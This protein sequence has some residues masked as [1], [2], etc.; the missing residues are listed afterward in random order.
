MARM[1]ALLD[2]ADGHRVLEIG[3]GTGYHAAL[4]SH[5]L[6]DTGVTSVDI[7][8]ALVGTARD[9]LAGLGYRPQLTAG[10]GAAGVA[11][12]APYNRIIA[13]CG[14]PEIP[15]AW[16]TQLTAGGLIVADV[17]SEVASSLVVAR[18]STPHSVTGRFLGHSG[19]FMWMRARVDN[20]LRTG[21]ASGA[22]YD[23]T[24]PATD[25]TNIPLAAFD[26]EDFRFVLQLAVPRLRPVGHTIRDGRDGIFLV[27]DDTP[28]WVE[29][30]PDTGRGSTVRYGGPRPLWPGIAAAWQSWNVKPG[31]G[32]R[33]P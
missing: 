16:I 9:R 22:V 27:T 15:P 33:A 20:P 6:G 3:T 19:H 11:G 1:L 21:G 12:Q 14:V 23:F 17:R 32:R 26:D 29:I 10:D 5:R 7:D 18:K 31:G 2:V 28:A 4:L 25:T 30:S 24:D 13:T 8:P